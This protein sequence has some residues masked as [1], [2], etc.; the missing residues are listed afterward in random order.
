[1]KSFSRKPYAGNLQ[2]RFDEEEGLAQANPPYS[3]ERPVYE[4]LVSS[5]WCMFLTESRR[6]GGFESG[7]RPRKSWILRYNFR[8]LYVDDCSDQESF[9]VPLVRQASLAVLVS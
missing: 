1:M 7:S 8:Q 3:T 4:T 2:V 5:N 9:S 6:H